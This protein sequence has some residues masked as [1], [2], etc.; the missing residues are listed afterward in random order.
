ML[1]SKM[2][3]NRRGDRGTEC[4]RERRRGG[5]QRLQEERVLIPVNAA[6]TTP[7]VPI[8]GVDKEGSLPAIGGLPNPTLDQGSSTF[9]FF[10]Q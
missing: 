8:P 4:G 6:P 5:F 10:Y 7:P 3:R 1:G 9:F 2:K